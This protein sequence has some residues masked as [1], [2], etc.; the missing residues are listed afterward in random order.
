[1]AL[2]L[3]HFRRSL[4][5]IKLSDGADEATSFYSTHY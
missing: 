5:P 1:M 2:V 3:P 4:A